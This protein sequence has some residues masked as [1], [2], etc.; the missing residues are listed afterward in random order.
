MLRKYKTLQIYPWCRLLRVPDRHSKIEKKNFIRE[1]IFVTTCGNRDL[2]W[3]N[4]EFILTTKMTG[5][6]FRWW[7]TRGIIFDPVQNLKEVVTWRICMPFHFWSTLIFGCYKWSG[8]SNSFKRSVLIHPEIVRT[9]SKAKF[10]TF[11]HVTSIRSKNL[12]WSTFKLFEVN[13]IV[14]VKSYDHVKYFKFRLWSSSN[15]LKVDQKQV[16]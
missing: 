1:N 4:F 11:Y 3:L 15:N 2:I 12:F 7:K 14:F 8:D 10:Q 5:S 6:H 16:L 9:G 13:H